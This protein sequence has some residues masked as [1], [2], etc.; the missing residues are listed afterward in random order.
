MFDI[1]Q[2]MLASSDLPNATYMAAV[3]DIIVNS[4]IIIIAKVG[5]V[6]SDDRDCSL[7]PYLQDHSIHPRFR[8]DYLTFYIYLHSAASLLICGILIPAF[9]IHQ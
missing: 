7:H 2:I 1:D 8:L 5:K 9:F 4:N 3:M 6:R